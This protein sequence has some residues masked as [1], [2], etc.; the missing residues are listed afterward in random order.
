MIFSNII[1]ILI[2]GVYVYAIG[3]ALGVLL[4][5]NR[6]PI[7]SIA[8]MLVLLFVPVLGLGLY[9]VF[10][11]NLRQ[12]K[13]MYKMGIRNQEP[14][15][16]NPFT[17]QD[18]DSADL[19]EK[20]IGLMRL[21][22]YN[23][24]ALVYSNSRID[25]YSEPTSTFDNIF[26]DI[27]SATDHIHVEFYIIEND[28]VGCRLRDVLIRKAQEGV[29]VR[30][31]YDYWGSLQVDKKFLKPLREAGV[32]CHAFFPPKFPLFL[33]HLNYRNHRKIIVIDGKIGYT[34][35]VNMADRYLNGNSLGS[36]RDTMIRFEGKVVHGL[37]ETF[38]S[39]W[40]FVD[41]NIFS[42]ARY[43][44]AMDDYPSKNLVQIVDSGPTN[45]FRSIM[46][47]INYAITTAKDYVYIQ[48]PYFMPPDVVA[49]TLQS[50]ALRGVDV[51]III[52]I[53]SDT[54]M[55]KASN[56]SYL[57]SMLDAGVKVYFYR[58]GFLHSKAIVIDDYISTVGTS[59]MD[60][61][62]YEQ[63]FE[64]NAFVYEEETAL[65]LRSLFLNDLEKT[66]MVDKEEWSKRPK[67]QRFR[68]SVSRLFSPI[69]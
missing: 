19:S 50:A 21:L 52:P 9:G 61:R 32:R 5:E 8:W 26:A 17:L 60:F 59:N 63:N 43:F 33:S 41:R 27:E 20:A 45:S 25:V 18:V 67:L 64:V 35:G 44:P 12:K 14:K 54:S 29:R 4:L 15:I 7:R 62:S 22:H 48:S 38:L 3:S 1:T 10:G 56:C 28:S 58:Q 69:M 47:G 11:Q 30:M 37:Q 6:S 39:D 16:D 51:R 55:A 31:I 68:E 57:D 2:V 46:Q 40:Y 13:R 49:D 36:W 66:E 24:H 34:G 65:R 42:G 23:D 53:S